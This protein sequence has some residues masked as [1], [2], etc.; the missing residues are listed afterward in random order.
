[1]VGSLGHLEVEGLLRG[2]ASGGS[3]DDV[4]LGLAR[5]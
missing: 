3:H 2:G 1:M 5:S 4:R